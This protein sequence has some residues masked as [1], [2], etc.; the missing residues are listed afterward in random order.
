MSSALPAA[1]RPMSVST[2]WLV[3]MSTMAALWSTDESHRYYG[4]F[5]CSCV[6]VSNESRLRKSSAFSAP[7]R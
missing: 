4:P 5:F 7:L 6:L 1:G 2:T 3:T